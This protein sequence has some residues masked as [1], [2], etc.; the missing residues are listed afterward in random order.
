MCSSIIFKNLESEPS[1]EKFVVSPV[2]V[3]SFKTREPLKVPKSHKQ[4]IQE[5]V[6]HEKTRRPNGGHEYSENAVRVARREADR[7]D[8]AW[9]GPDCSGEVKNHRTFYRNW[10]GS[11]TV[12]G[13][14]LRWTSLQVD[15][16]QYLSTGWQ[17]VTWYV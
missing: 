6:I 12:R 13:F 5:G 7:E 8:L 4:Q 2:H 17:A 16:G 15:K 11:C 3:G 9:A 14:K 10:R 1:G